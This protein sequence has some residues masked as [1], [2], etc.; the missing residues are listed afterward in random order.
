[1][2]CWTRSPLYLIGTLAALLLGSPCLADPG[3]SEPSIQTESSPP[4]VTP[5]QSIQGE[6]KQEEP[7]ETTVEAVDAAPGLLGQ[8][9]VSKVGRIGRLHD[10]IR[11]DKRRRSY[12]LEVKELY[13]DY[14][15]FKHRLDQDA[16]L[17]WSVDLSY[18]P[19]WAGP[20]GGSPSTQLLTT[21]NID[22]RLFRSQSLGEGSVQA[23]YTTARYPSSQNGADLSGTV[24][25][26]N[27]IND[28]PVYQNT[29]SQLSYTHALPGNKVLITVGQY[30]FY[31]F[32]G[33]LYLANQQENFNSYI[34]SQNG[35]S[36]YPIAGLGAYMQVNV[37][38]AIQIAAGLQ[39]PNNLSG[40]TLATPNFK[41]AGAAW[42]GYLQ[43]TPQFRGLGTAQYSFTYYQVPTVPEQKQSSGWSF[44]AMQNLN[45]TW[46]LFARANSAYQ[47]FAPIRS[48]YALGAAM[49]NPLGRNKLDQIGLAIGL[50]VP[51]P[52][53]VNPPGARNEKVLEAYW[54]WAFTGAVLITPSIQVIFD[55]AL[56]PDRRSAWSLSLRATLTL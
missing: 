7:A 38:D 39:N 56:V 40:S 30:P 45:D 52:S 55:P 13:G 43:W 27:L 51:A 12:F 8:P 6:Q 2:T 15:R 18:L 50:S 24:G 10:D 4:E 5:P 34:F 23:S 47:T 28:F 42:F 41:T 35:S 46:A 1:M 49:N 48:S 37:T 11:R 22:Y 32:D 16:G 19:Q 25:V 29:F 20:E 26:I 17:T 14:A 53:P 54:N 21:S 33:N 44:N 9:D 36:T 31:S 3:G